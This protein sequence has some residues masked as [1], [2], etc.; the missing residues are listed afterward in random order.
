MFHRFTVPASEKNAIIVHPLINGN[1]IPVIA[2]YYC[3]PVFVYRKQRIELY[4]V[5][6]DG[7]GEENDV[8]GSLYE[9]V[10]N[11]KFTQHDF[12]I[13]STNGH[14]TVTRYNTSFSRTDVNVPSH[15]MIYEFLNG[16][17]A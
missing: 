2:G 10:L 12:S 8:L 13:A 11:E 4:V 15:E 3:L 6:V 5:P 16:A 7:L 14:L 9:L 17:E 1:D